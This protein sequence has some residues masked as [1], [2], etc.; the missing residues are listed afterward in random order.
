[1]VHAIVVPNITL[2][3]NWER[4]KTGIAKWWWVGPRMSGV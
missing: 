1:M 4:D 2:S 3:V